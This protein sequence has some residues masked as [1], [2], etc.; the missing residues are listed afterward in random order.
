MN[1]NK[2][3]VSNQINEINMFVTN[4]YAFPSKFILDLQ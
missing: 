3:H 2:L 4:A 1:I